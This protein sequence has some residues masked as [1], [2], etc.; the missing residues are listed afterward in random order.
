[1][2]LTIVCIRCFHIGPE[3]VITRGSFLL[4][5]LLL[6][7][8][9][10]WI[11]LHQLPEYLNPFLSYEGVERPVEIIPGNILMVLFLLITIIYSVWRWFFTYNGC[12]S[13]GSRE[14]VAAK[15]SRGKKFIEALEKRDW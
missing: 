7:G 13:C 15:S 14:T 3:K 11:A 6:L 9:L 4:Q 10:F 8:S 1:M 2:A 5:F 12:L